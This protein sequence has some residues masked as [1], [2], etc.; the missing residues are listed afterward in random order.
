MPVLLVGV[1]FIDVT[2]VALCMIDSSLLRKLLLHYGFMF[3][4]CLWFSPVV[5]HVFALSFA[6]LLD[7]CPIVVPVIYG[8]GHRLSRAR[9]DSATFLLLV[10]AQDSM[11]D[12]ARTKD[13]S[14][15]TKGLA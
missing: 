1:P 10:P 3:R 15:I 9:K 4:V 5:A 13:R 11:V 12:R 14:A 7:L 8:L 2:R 6:L